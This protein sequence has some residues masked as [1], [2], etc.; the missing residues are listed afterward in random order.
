MRNRKSLLAKRWLALLLVLL[1]AGNLTMIS[2]CASGE[3]ADDPA[4]AATVTET[5]AETVS[6]TE[7]EPEWA[8]PEKNFDGETVTFILRKT[9]DDWSA[10]DV[11]ATE[12]NGTPVND[13]V[14]T[15]N[16]RIEEA[17]NVKLVGIDA[18]TD[19]SIY[20][21][22]MNSVLAND[23]AFDVSVSYQHDAVKF[24]LENAFMDLKEQEYLQLDQSWWNP[25]Y[26]SNVSMM[27]KQF[28][29]LGDISRVYKL[30]V[31]CLFFNKDLAEDLQL[32]N[33]YDL[34]RE[35]KWDYDTFF[36][37]ASMGNLDLDGNGTMDAADQY[38]IQAQSSL[39]ITLAMGGGLQLT[40]KD[41]ADKPLLTANNE[42]NLEILSRLSE[43]V[44]SNK[45]SIYTSDNWLNTQT[46][47]SE[48][49]VLFQAEVMLLIEALRASE[50]NVGILPMPKWDES[51]EY[52]ISYLDAHCQNVY[53]IPVTCPNPE[54]VSFV[55]EAMAQGSLDTLT[56][57]F[58]DVCLNGKYIRDQESSD[59]LDIIFAH[60]RTEN[61]ETFGWGNMY[62]NL[63]SAI[64]AGTAASS[65]ERSVKAA[66]KAM[67]RTVTNFCAS[68]G[69]EI[70]P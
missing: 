44:N 5:E 28:Y 39:S 70:A 45:S 9:P 8:L 23:N 17:Y 11:V 3:T 18:P 16:A 7:T 68:Q 36:S 12:T 25:F 24:M 59:M 57:A 55:L 34:V 63:N 14:Y 56:T 54:K 48:N 20:N 41:E 19:H 43:A 15:R 49:K 29:A 4:T 46:R 53:G 50:V 21:A 62:S 52:Y 42:Q 2:S 61:A 38:G 47:F 58:Y 33:L 35:N 65:I 26:S 69:I 22:V 51:Q 1:T 13:A 37:L 6:E 64:P 10:D 67:E 27:G 30:G 40:G 66:Q 31:R 60:C 32:G